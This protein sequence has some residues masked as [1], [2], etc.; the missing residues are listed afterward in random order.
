MFN[1]E[2]YIKYLQSL[3]NKTKANFDKQ[4][5]P[6][7]KYK[8]LGIYSTQITKIV[9]YIYKKCFLEYLQN[10]EHKF[11]YQEEVYIYSYLIGKIKDVK[12]YKHYLITYLK[13]NTNWATNDTASS[14]KIYKL[15]KTNF[16]QTDELFNFIYTLPKTYK[17]KYKD[18]TYI[19][20]YSLIIMKSFYIREE[21]ISK[22]LTFIKQN[23]MDSYYYK[24]MAS[25]LL[26]TMSIKFKNEVI[27]FLNLI[28]D[29]TIIKMAIQK[30]IESRFTN[31]EEKNYYKQLKTTLLTQ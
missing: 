27:S 11:I 8:I 25:W 18:L 26:Q 14:H 16:K 5:I 21:Y 12:T 20:R 23:N 6:N 1:Y 3:E 31:E 2:E 28:E 24:M 10:K 4:L 30:I 15:T 19:K 17:N 22:I 7:T 9:Q 29:K 13:L